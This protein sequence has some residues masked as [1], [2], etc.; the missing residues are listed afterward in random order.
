MVGGVAVSWL[1]PSCGEVPVRSEEEFCF[2]CALERATELG[3]MS[4]P[5]EGEKSIDLV[6]GE[7][8]VYLGGAWKR[9]RP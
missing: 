7:P 2:G 4:S 8:I 9:V 1:C 6:T 5:A 3:E